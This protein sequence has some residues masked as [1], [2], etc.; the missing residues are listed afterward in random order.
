MHRNSKVDEQ[1]DPLNSMLLWEKEFE[2]DVK[3][4]ISFNN[5]LEDVNLIT[6]LFNSF[7]SLQYLVGSSRNK[8]DGLL[9]ISSPMASLLHSPPDKREMRVC[10]LSAK[11]NSFNTCSTYETINILL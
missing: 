11:P 3:C 7:N 2:N 6:L 10:R 9:M 4:I 1:K 5:Q 8:M